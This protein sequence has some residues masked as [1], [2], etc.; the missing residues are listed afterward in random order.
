MA[1][2]FHFACSQPVYQVFD[3]VYTFDA[4]L[5]RGLGLSAAWLVGIAGLF[6]ILA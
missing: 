2:V 3:L 6:S 4:A 5:Y 1:F